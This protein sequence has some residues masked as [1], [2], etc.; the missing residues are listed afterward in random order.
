MGSGKFTLARGPGIGAKIGIARAWGE[1]LGSDFSFEVPIRQ[2]GK[3]NM[4][5][6]REGNTCDTSGKFRSSVIL[7][8]FQM[9]SNH[10]GLA[11]S[12]LD[13]AGV[14]YFHHC[15]WFCWSALL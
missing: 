13:S 15:R 12:I 2:P 4:Y 10:V 9:P 6:I 14:E 3:R 11:A 1:R 5:K 7:V 8:T